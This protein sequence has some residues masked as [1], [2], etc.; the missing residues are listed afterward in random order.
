MHFVSLFCIFTKG[1]NF[2]TKGSEKATKRREEKNI[3]KYMKWIFSFELCVGQTC[4]R[5]NGLF[6]IM[7]WEE[8][9]N[10]CGSRCTTDSSTSPS[11]PRLCKTER[12]RER[13]W[14]REQ[15]TSLQFRSAFLGNSY[16]ATITKS[17]VK[18]NGEESQTLTRNS[19]LPQQLDSKQGVYFLFYYFIYFLQTRKDTNKIF[20][21][22]CRRKLRRI[23]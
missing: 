9:T 14:E 8:E 3:I 11:A 16:Q 23:M 20:K 1:T 5:Y 13:E 21:N 18:E 4:G 22:A 12:R 2:E 6:A 17:V 19:K 7:P 10:G 15:S